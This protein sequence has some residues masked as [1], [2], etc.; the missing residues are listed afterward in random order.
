MCSYDK[1]SS[2]CI[3]CDRKLDVTYKLKSH[4][5]EIVC[6]DINIK[7]ES[8]SSIDCGCT[9]FSEAAQ[10]KRK[11]SDVGHTDSKRRRD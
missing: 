10:T 5:Q 2:V 8:V 11:T 4:C 9:D 1:A 3:Y 6:L 7:F